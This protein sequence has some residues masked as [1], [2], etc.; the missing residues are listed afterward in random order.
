MFGALA[1]NI[2]FSSLKLTTRYERI[3]QKPR[4]VL[5]SLYD[6]QK[7][8]IEGPTESQKMMRVF[9]ERSGWNCLGSYSQALAFSNGG[10]L[11]WKGDLIIYLTPC[12]SGT[13]AA[14]ATELTIPL[15]FTQV[16]EA[17]LSLEDLAFRKFR[18]VHEKLSL[19]RHVRLICQ[20]HM[21][22]C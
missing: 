15:G 9:S 8:S 14:E 19:W 22:F 20:Y 21:E 11:G 13:V 7:P 5:I 2:S 16:F 4:W 10:S 1:L 3:R 12:V 17:I 18:L 6:F